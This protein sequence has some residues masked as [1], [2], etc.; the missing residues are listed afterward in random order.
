MRE[1]DAGLLH[2]GTDWA[3]RRR[4]YRWRKRREMEQDKTILYMKKER[5]KG[6]NGRKKCVRKDGKIHN[7]TSRPPLF[8]VSILILFHIAELFI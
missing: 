2:V 4:K 1:E 7:R 8:C 3:R 6:E 5:K